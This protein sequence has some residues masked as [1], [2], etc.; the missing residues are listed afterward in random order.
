MIFQISLYIGVV[1]TSV[2]M[3]FFLIRALLGPSISDRILALDSLGITLVGFT[4]LVMMLQETSVYA[5]VVLVLA[6]LSF[7]GTVAL[8][9]FIE[10]GAVIDRDR[11]NR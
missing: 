10:R 9:K 8:S 5:D 6:I 4:G 1:G 3:I 11:N 7:V 2:A